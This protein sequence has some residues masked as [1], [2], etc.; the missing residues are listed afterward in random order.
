MGEAV[1]V[2]AALVV[3]ALAVEEKATAAMAV[4]HWEVGATAVVGWKAV[5]V[6]GEVMVQ[7]VAM[8]Q[9]VREVGCSGKW[10][11]GCMSRVSD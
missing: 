11:Y 3:V 9:A 1:L 7:A 2:A 6:A 8:V 4:D 10:D 5:R